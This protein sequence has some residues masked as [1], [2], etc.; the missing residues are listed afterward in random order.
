M[1]Y[2][3]AK[4]KGPYNMSVLLLHGQSFSSETWNSLGTLKM[5]AA[6]GYNSIAVDLPG[7]SI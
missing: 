2:L 1:H 7:L 6:F 3:Q 5:L 4:P